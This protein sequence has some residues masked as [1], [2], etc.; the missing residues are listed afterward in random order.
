MEIEKFAG[1]WQ[2]LYAG[3]KLDGKDPQ[4][5]VSSQQIEAFALYMNELLEW[6][7]KMN[8]TNITLPHQVITKHFLDCLVGSSLIPQNASVIDIGTGA[9]FPG[10]VLNIHRPDASFVLM[11]ALQKRLN[12]LDE[13]VR[14][15]NLKNT[16]LVHDRAEDAG[17]KKEYREQF[18]VSCARA[19]AS[20]PCLLEY[21]IPFV[22][23]GGIFLAYKGPGLVEEVE[24][25][26]HA[27]KVLGCRVEAIHTVTMASIQSPEGTSEE[28]W[29]H[30]IA[31]IRKEKPTHSIY[32]RKQAKIK[33]N[34]L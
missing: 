27:L 25:A 13:V 2:R 8:L 21:S 11:D 7:E 28:G 1:E 24:E 9:G 33:S 6:N 10:M 19:V 23:V 26:Q 14:E 16:R 15:L 17:Q 29:E 4:L 30:K 12:F 34:P 5:S 32:P 22:K 18:D 3:L 20:L 31:V